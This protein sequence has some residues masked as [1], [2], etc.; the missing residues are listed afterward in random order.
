ME[1]FGIMVNCLPKWLASHLKTAEIILALDG[2]ELKMFIGI[3]QL[4]E[5]DKVMVEQV[6]Q[7]VSKQDEGK[8]GKEIDETNN[9]KDEEGEVEKETFR[10]EFIDQNADDENA[11]DFRWSDIRGEDEIGIA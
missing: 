7:P 6:E 11:I 2:S 4:Q 1:R 5:D 8:K 10:I 3:N 9:N